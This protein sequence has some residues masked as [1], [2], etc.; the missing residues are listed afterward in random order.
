MPDPTPHK[1]TEKTRELV[2]NL[3]VSGARQEQICDVLEVSKKT[4]LKYYR[5]EIDTGITEANARVVGAL[6]ANAM[7]GNVAAQIFWCKVR[8]YVDQC[9][10]FPVGFFDSV[11]NDK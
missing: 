1:P 4:L 2:T 3:S 9:V 5:K 7:A 10:V 8:W 11:V 6:F